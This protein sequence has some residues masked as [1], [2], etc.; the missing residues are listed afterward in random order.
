MKKKTFGVSFSFCQH[1]NRSRK[2]RCAKFK[3]RVFFLSS[4]QGR[5]VCRFA[6]KQ[7]STPEM[8]VNDD[9]EYLLMSLFRLE[10]PQ[11]KNKRTSSF[12]C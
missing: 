5:L 1:N 4:F 2:T 11:K 10:I 3:K 7:L 9:G 12:G 8:N 6:M